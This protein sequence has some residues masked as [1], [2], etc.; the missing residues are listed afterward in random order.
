MIT[1]PEPSPPTVSVAHL[2]RHTQKTKSVISPGPVT[3]IVKGYHLGKK[4]SQ[5]GHTLLFFFWGGQKYHEKRMN[6]Q[7]SSFQELILLATSN[8]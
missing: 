4:G 8:T 3:A 7:F 2:Q 1:T 6:Y 5:S